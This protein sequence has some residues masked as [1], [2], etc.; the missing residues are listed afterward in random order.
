MD[1]LVISSGVGKLINTSLV[2]SDRLCGA[3]L[4]ADK[5]Q[6]GRLGLLARSVAIK[7]SLF[8]T[9]FITVADIAGSLFLRL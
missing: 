1:P 2:D 6:T 8:L 7:V 4:M 5:D 3:E 9:K